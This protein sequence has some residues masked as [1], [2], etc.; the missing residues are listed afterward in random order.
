MKGNPN[1]SLPRSVARTALKDQ[2]KIKKIQEYTGDEFEDFMRYLKN[3]NYYDAQFAGR[4]QRA[5]NIEM[6]Q[7]R[8]Q[9]LDTYE[10]DMKF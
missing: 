1:R 7:K 4:L 2:T 3:D 5:L 6:D 8:K 9:I 10:E